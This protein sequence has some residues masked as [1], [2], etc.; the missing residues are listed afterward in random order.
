M[1]THIS[2]GDFPV[3]YVNV[4][5]AG[6]S[7]VMSP[8]TSIVDWFIPSGPTGMDPSQTSFFQALKKKPRALESWKMLL[9]FFLMFSIIDA[10]SLRSSFLVLRYI[11]IYAHIMIYIYICIYMYIYT[12]YIYNEHIYMYTPYIHY[13]YVHYIY[14]Y[15][16]YIIFPINFSRSS[17]SATRPWTSVPRS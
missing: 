1:T 2:H 17:H 9:Y 12:L 6:Y 10:S 4:Y 13:I 5:Q 3:C 15:N 16:V 8:R 14:I 7:Y 11:Y